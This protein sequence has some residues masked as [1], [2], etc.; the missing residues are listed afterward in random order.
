[1][2][3]R[4]KAALIAAA[5]VIIAAVIGVTGP[6][7]HSSGGTASATQAPTTQA[8]TTGAPPTQNAQPI[9]FDPVTTSTVP[10]CASFTGEGDVPQDRQLWIVVKTNE[11]GRTKYYYDETSAV[12]GQWSAPKVTIGSATDP[13]GEL[14]TVEAV[15]F[16]NT[17]SQ[18][19]SSG[20]YQYGTFDLPSDA[21]PPQDQIGVKLGDDHT[22]C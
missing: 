21:S 19:I 12:G 1:M 8:P 18:D 7:T 2:D 4:T 9:R 17:T 22:A 3:G 20:R 16:T 14:F 10:R 6:W 15:T 11:S 13:T 5:G